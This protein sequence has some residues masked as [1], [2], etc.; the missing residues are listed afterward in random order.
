MRC[1]SQLVSYSLLTIVFTFYFLLHLS[2][3][4]FF[5]SLKST[6]LAFR[7]AGLCNCEIIKKI[8]F[9]LVTKIAFHIMHTSL[10]PPAPASKLKA[11]SEGATGI[12]VWA[13]LRFVATH[14]RYV[15]VS[16]FHDGPDGQATD[17]FVKGMYCTVASTEIVTIT[18]DRFSRSALHIS[19]KA[20]PP[21]WL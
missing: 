9:V 18:A 6:I 17:G 15:K 14:M 21:W 3:V 12:T 19:N 16:S 1:K 20:L 13:Y 8:P 7:S 4:A 10:N 5:R 2:T 11:V